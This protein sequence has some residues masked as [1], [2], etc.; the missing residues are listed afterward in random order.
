MRGR[1]EMFKTWTKTACTPFAFGR[2]IS[3][4]LVFRKHPLQTTFRIAP[5]DRSHLRQTPSSTLGCLAISL[6][7]H[8]EIPPRCS[9]EKES[10]T[11]TLIPLTQRMTQCLGPLNEL[12]A[13]QW[14]L[15]FDRLRRPWNLLNRTRLVL[16]GRH[17]AALPAGR[18]TVLHGR[19][20][21]ERGQQRKTRV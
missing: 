6:P 2:T 20:F 5:E 14:L 15:L 3:R 17:R 9:K 1:W 4:R 10:E 12:A 7:C 16:P 11:L 18:D 19:H 21:H 8:H 13:L